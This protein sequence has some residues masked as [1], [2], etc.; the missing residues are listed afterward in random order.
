[1]RRNLNLSPRTEHVRDQL[2]VKLPVQFNLLEIK[3]HFD[4]SLHSIRKQFDVAEYLI[5]V[6]KFKEAENIFRS[7]I[8]FLESILDFFMH[9]IT[10]FGLY[11]I[12]TKEWPITEKFNNLEIP[13]SKLM[14]ALT[15][16]ES[17]EWFSNM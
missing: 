4:E 15:D 13:M 2:L 8:V 5:S 11:R 9:E 10:K 7:Q 1:M 16:T 6:G 3:E 17:T 12:F 14:N